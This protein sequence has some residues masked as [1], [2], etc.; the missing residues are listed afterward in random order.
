[1]IHAGDIPV[2]IITRYDRHSVGSRYVRIHQEDFCQARAIYSD[3]KYQND[4]GPSVEAI[5]NTIWDV[6]S[7]ALTDIRNF[8]DALLLN[9]L[10]YRPAM[11]TPRIFHCSWQ[12]TIKC[13]SH[14]F[15]T[16]PVHYLTHFKYLRRKLN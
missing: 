3:L 13:A 16:S 6:S 4:G 1:V 11:P 15:T 7:D 2:I 5:A 8:A 10:I 9:F 12:A 14:H